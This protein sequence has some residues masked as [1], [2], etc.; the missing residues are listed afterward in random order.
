MFFYSSASA[1]MMLVFILMLEYRDRGLLFGWPSQFHNSV[2]SR[3]LRLTY[4]VMYLVRRYHGYSF[5]W[6]MV[7]TCWY[8]PFE[9]TFGHITGCFNIYMIL[10]Q[11]SLAM[12]SFHL[13][14][15]WRF[16]LE[17]WVTIHGGIVAYQTGGPMLQ[18][19]SFWPMFTFGFLF[20]VFVTQVSNHD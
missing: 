15:Y 3:R 11:G 17:T 5:A 14:K 13:N 12:T 2:W 20:V 19:T 6:A 4:S 18:Y 1:I 10:L 8:H 9:G 7:W 16:I